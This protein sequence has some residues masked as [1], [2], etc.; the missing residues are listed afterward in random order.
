[1]K[2]SGR[3]EAWKDGRSG[4]EHLRPSPPPFQS[5]N[6]FTLIELLVVVAIIAILAAMLLPALQDAKEQAK[7]SQCMNNQK[8]VG[9]ALLIMGDDHNGWLDGYT[10]GDHIWNPQTNAWDRDVGP[11]LGGT[12][13][14]YP[15]WA[16]GIGCPGMAADDIRGPY[17]ANIQ[18]VSYAAYTD[19]FGQRHNIAEVKRPNLV[20]LVSESWYPTC[21]NLPYTY[22]HTVSGCAGD[23]RARHRGKGLNFFFVDGHSEWLQARGGF[24]GQYIT[25]QASDWWKWGTRHGFAP[26]FNWQWFNPAWDGTPAYN[27]FILYGQ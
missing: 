26:P 11:Y 5:S 20:Y 19:G 22:D 23:P 1:M 4:S 9:M 3:M 14:T 25:D 16:G 15:K 18:L 2:R 10:T 13:L 21:N 24:Y 27:Y 7:R 17:A 6:S 8:Q 12:K